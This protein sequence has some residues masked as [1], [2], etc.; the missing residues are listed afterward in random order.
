MK[1]LNA[2]QIYEKLRQGN[3]IYEEKKHC[4]MLL[5]IL[6]AKWR[7]GAFCVEALITEACFYNWVNKH[8]VFKMCYGVAQLLAHEAWE[9]EELDNEVNENWDRKTWLSRGSRY[10][11]KDKAKIKLEVDFMATPWVQYQQILKQ[12]QKGDFNASEI[13]QLMESI[14]VGTRVY[15]TFKLQAEVDT[16]KENLKEMSERHG[17]DTIAVVKTSE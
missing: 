7:I 12:A 4:V 10:F 6:P 17:N 14:N 1:Q 16:M 13:K 8:E 9:K 3:A 2:S 15:E 11:S 5:E